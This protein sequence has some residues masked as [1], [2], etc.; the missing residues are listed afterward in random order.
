MVSRLMVR[1]S[2]PISSFLALI[3][4]GSVAQAVRADHQRLS[5][6]NREDANQCPHNT[7]RMGFRFSVCPSRPELCGKLEVM[8]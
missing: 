3:G 4:P 1:T 6:F 2:S 8:A 7:L 5:G